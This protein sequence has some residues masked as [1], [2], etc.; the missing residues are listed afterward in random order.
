MLFSNR[1][2]LKLMSFLKQ[3]LLKPTSGIAILFLID[4]LLCLY[5]MLNCKRYR[6]L[7]Q[8]AAL[9]NYCGVIL[10]L[11]VFNR[12]NGTAREIRLYFDPWIIS[13]S[14]F[15]FHES[16]ILIFLLDCIYFIPFGL[17]VGLQSIRAYRCAVSMCLILL[18]GIGVET[19]QFVFGRGVSSIGDIT[20]Y[21][22]GGVIGFS[23][24]TRLVKK[25][26]NDYFRCDI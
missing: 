24:A 16:N 23:I 3:Y 1:Q 13:V 18:I 15:R 7:L 2:W 8:K 9:M 25:Y 5:M 11:S 4:C 22:I 14:G 19:L 10:S 12:E 20:A 26:N 21:F 17:L 6:E